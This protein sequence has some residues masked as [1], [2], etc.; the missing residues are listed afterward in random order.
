MI[1]RSSLIG[2]V[3]PLS[4]IGVGHVSLPVVITRSKRYE[5]FD[6]HLDKDALAE[7]RAWFAKFEDSQ[8]PKGNTTFARSSGAGGQHVNK[9]GLC[10]HSDLNVGLM[11]QER[12]PRL[13]LSTL[14]GSSYLCYPKLS[15]RLFDHRAIT[16]PTTT[17]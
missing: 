6:A 17:P 14:Y 4:A 16:Q 10:S 12:R 2:F 1:S 15:T 7:A 9:Y 13:S 5:A 11:Y 8:L 3:R